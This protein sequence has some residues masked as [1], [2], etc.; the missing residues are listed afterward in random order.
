MQCNAVPDSVVCVSQRQ[1]MV[2]W[3]TV[4]HLGYLRCTLVFPVSAAISVAHQCG[5][6]PPNRPVCFVD[7]SDAPCGSMANLHAIEGATSVINPL[8]GDR[9]SLHAPGIN[10]SV[11]NLDGSVSENQLTAFIV[12]KIMTGEV[13]CAVTGKLRILAVINFQSNTHCV[14]AIMILPQPLSAIIMPAHDDA[15]V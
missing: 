9:T 15:L 1:S 8:V 7:S 13:E 10:F 4:A 3:G 11:L 2:F 5:I 12:P 14:R 6:M